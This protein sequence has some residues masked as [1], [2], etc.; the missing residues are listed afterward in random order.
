[1]QVIL[2]PFPDTRRTP[3]QLAT[4]HSS[5]IF[6]V[7]LLPGSGNAQLATC[8]GDGTVQVGALGE[9]LG[10]GWGRS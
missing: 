9:G 6:G 3:L 8:A 2:W 1:L 7:Q 5:N 10:E 4:A